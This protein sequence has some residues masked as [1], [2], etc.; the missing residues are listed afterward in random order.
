MKVARTREELQA[1]RAGFSGAVGFVPTM[2]ALHAGHASLMEQSVT[3]NPHTLVSIFVNPKQFAPGEDLERY[4]R[5]LDADLAMCEQLGVDAVFVPAVELMYPAGFSTI[6]EVQGLG[7]RLCGASRPGHFT[8]V[9]TVVAKLFNLVQPAR[10]YFGQ[11]DAQQA[12]ILSRMARD[13]NLPVEV[14][15]CPTVR[16]P[17]GLALSSRNRYLSTEERSRAVSLNAALRVT[18]EAYA[19]GLRAADELRGLCWDTLE[20]GLSPKD[21]VDYVE[22]LDAEDLS[23]VDTLERPALCAVAVWV[24][25]TR[26]IDNEILGG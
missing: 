2:G 18:A 4:P 25:E 16:E 11:K 14:I 24:G 22:I 19:K 26:L 6:V 21:R 8:G 23:E 13:L 12:I 7:D 15:T 1:C 20:N 3:A 10:A 5:T 17:D 9:S